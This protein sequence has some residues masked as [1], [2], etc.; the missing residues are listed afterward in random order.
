MKWN[1]LMFISAEAVA[2]VARNLV[3][4]QV[5]QSAAGTVVGIAIAVSLRE[6]SF[7]IGPKVANVWRN[8]RTPAPKLE[9]AAKAA[10]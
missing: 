5:A 1:I 3:T 7:Y 10:A 4:S 9:D 6:A 8:F 2:N